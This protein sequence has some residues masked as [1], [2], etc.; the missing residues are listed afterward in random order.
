MWLEQCRDV[1]GKLNVICTLVRALLYLRCSCA[2]DLTPWRLPIYSIRH[3]CEAP[4]W[5]GYTVCVRTQFVRTTVKLEKATTTTDDD[6]DTQTHTHTQNTVKYRKSEFDFSVTQF[7][8]ACYFIWLNVIFHW[9]KSIGH[10]VYARSSTYTHTHTR[11]AGGGD[12]VCCSQLDFSI[13]Q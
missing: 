11:E 10:V 7:E 5:N 9:A 1:G 6:H 4:I 13:F 3:L 2:V 12:S 8:Y